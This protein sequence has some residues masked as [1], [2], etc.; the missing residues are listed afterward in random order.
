MSSQQTL[1]L[2]EHEPL[3]LENVL[4]VVFFSSGTSEVIIVYFKAGE[5]STV[6]PATGNNKRGLSQVFPE[7]F[8]YD[9]E[10]DRDAVRDVPSETFDEKG[11]VTQATLGR[12]TKGNDVIYVLRE[13]PKASGGPRTLSKIDVRPA[14]PERAS[15]LAFFEKL[16]STFAK[17]NALGEIEAYKPRMDSGEKPKV[18]GL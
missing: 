17:V 18:P 13:V 10:R 16:G 7:S 3:E 4:S 1:S 9:V 14:N 15:I 2:E 6:V 11:T 12:D 8:R 5:P